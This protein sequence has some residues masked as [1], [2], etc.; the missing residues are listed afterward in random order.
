MEEFK[1]LNPKKMLHPKNGMTLE[2]L[3]KQSAIAALIVSN[4]EKKGYKQLTEEEIQTVNKYM[5]R[6]S[7]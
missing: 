6:Y 4:D 3:D 1:F 7:K 2:Y 5:A